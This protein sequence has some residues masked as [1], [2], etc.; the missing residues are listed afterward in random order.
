MRFRAFIS[1]AAFLLIIII[2]II[3]GPGCA[4]IVPPQ[5]GP[6]DTIPP[7]LLK[8]TPGDSTRNFTGNKISF[9]FDEFVDIQSISENLMVSPSPRLNPMVEFK[10]NT[11]TVKL[12]D[13][14]ESNTTYS[15]NFG[16]AIKDY[17]EGNALKDFTYTFS[18]GRYIDSLELTG[19]V[20]LAETGNTDTTLIVMLHTSGD[21]SAVIKDRP[22][23][24][25]KLDSKGNF[26]F[27]NLPPK[28]FYIYA[29]KD[30]GGTRR[31]LS[32]KQLFAFADKP[33]MPAIKADP[34]QLY[35]Y[36]V[37]E[38]NK[39]ATSTSSGP[40]KTITGKGK[41]LGA[42]N[43]L[44][45]TTSLV[46]DQQDLLSRFFM[47]FDQPLRVFDSTKI[48]LYTDSTF[49][50]APAYSF[51]KDSTGKNIQ[52]IHTWKEN[53]LY[54]IIMDKD[55]AEDSLGK[56]LLKTDTL[57]FRTK[58]L[59]DYG[60]LQLKFR[61]LDMK[62][63]PVLLF[64]SGET[65]SRMVPLTSDSFS[66]P[67]LLP[68]EYELRVLYDDNKNGIWDPGQFFG[69]HKQPELVKPIERRITVKPAWQNEFEINVQ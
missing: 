4:N 67:S 55:F 27:K 11:V 1:S 31:Y 32:N 47:S 50:S 3:S 24:I 60:S 57:S 52:L 49:T 18:T 22:R 61:N 26:I 51:Q 65:V 25:A 21:D 43:R 6:R 63:N 58:K 53:T 46:N 28:N 66:D 19:Q 7:V 54:H 30:E 35:A 45:Y 9:T 16:N 59:A 41:N 39:P 40:L 5:G 37:K 29:L 12:K 33:V 69:K 15:I 36:A 38:T 2:S 48:R 34:V 23:Y 20:I 17:T 42:D 68:G 10:L 64:V 44:K 8:A 13:S 62:K 14:L 56:K